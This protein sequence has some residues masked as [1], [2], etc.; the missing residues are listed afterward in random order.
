[1]GVSRVVGVKRADA[2]ACSSID[3]AAAALNSLLATYA[4]LL[5]P[6]ALPH[7]IL[8]TLNFLSAGCGQRY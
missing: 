6:T 4:A 2:H 1:M 7:L 5:P 8:A 3:C